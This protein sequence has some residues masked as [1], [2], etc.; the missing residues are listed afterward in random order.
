MDFGWL[1]SP[2]SFRDFVLSFVHRYNGI[3]APLLV[4]ARD[5]PLAGVLRLIERIEVVFLSCSFLLSLVNNLLS[6]SS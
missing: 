5:N 3:S 1:F 6:F 2:S 4:G